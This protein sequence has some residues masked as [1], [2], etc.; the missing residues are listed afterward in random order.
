MKSKKTK[1]S[2]VTHTFIMWLC[3][4]ARRWLFLHKNR[5]QLELNALQCTNQASPGQSVVELVELQRHRHGSDKHLCCEFTLI[6][7][8]LASRGRGLRQCNGMD[9]RQIQHCDYE[10]RL[11]LIESCK[12]SSIYPLPCGKLTAREQRLEVHCARNADVK[13]DWNRWTSTDFI[14]TIRIFCWK[15]E[16]C[17]ASAV[18]ILKVFKLRL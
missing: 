17:F 15:V 3:W 12:S 7:E 14:K 18:A 11:Q 5:F 9:Y 13:R 8:L 1:P 10:R 6:T 4:R 2:W 16:L